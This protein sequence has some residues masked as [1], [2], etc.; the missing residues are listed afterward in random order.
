M[1]CGSAYVVYIPESMNHYTHY[2][3]DIV[4]V[5]ILYKLGIG[6]RAS[7]INGHLLGIASM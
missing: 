4:I 7:N 2:I 6:L 1:G 3:I 5:N